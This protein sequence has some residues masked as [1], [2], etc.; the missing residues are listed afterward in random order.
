MSQY[1][2]QETSTF[3]M[4]ERE[5][6]NAERVGKLGLFGGDTNPD[7]NELDEPTFLREQEGRGRVSDAV[8]DEPKERKLDVSKCPACGQRHTGVPAF[9]GDGG[10]WVYNCPFDN[11]PCY[12][13]RTGFH[14]SE[15]D[16]V[17][18]CVGAQA[19][20][21]GVPLNPPFGKKVIIED[22][23]GPEVEPTPVVKPPEPK[24]NEADS[25]PAFE[26]AKQLAER[27]QAIEW[28]KNAIRT[29]LRSLGAELEFIQETRKRFR[30][31]SEEVI[32][33]ND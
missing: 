5:R 8:D 17:K 22:N 26:M 14:L 24:M 18:L 11:V 7:P 32:Q 6:T 10:V 21:A 20:G 4:E 9:Q 19:A 31:M 33:S 1:T 2:N 12:L 27:E 25:W 3:E 13:D 29:E 30:E 15:P 23:M 28:R 16:E